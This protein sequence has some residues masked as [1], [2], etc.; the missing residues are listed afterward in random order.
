[1]RE[2]AASYERLLHGMCAT[3]QVVASQH[4]ELVARFDESEVLHPG[5]SPVAVAERIRQSA[6]AYH[7]AVEQC[8]LATAPLP[9]SGSGVPHGAALRASGTRSAAGALSPA[10]IQNLRAVVASALGEPTTSTPFEVGPTAAATHGEYRSR[11]AMHTRTPVGGGLAASGQGDHSMRF[12][13]GSSTLSEVHELRISLHTLRLRGTIADQAQGEGVRVSISLLPASLRLPMLTTPT[14]GLRGKELQLNYDERLTFSSEG[15]AHRQLVALLADAVGGGT[16]TRR[17]AAH[18]V[19][20]HLLLSSISTGGVV[21]TIGEATVP[22]PRLL[23]PGAGSRLPPTNLTN[24]N[25][26]ITADVELGAIAPG[27]LAAAERAATEANVIELQIHD[28]EIEPRLLR[29]AWGVWVQTDLFTLAYAASED[30]A[31]ENARESRDDRKSALVCTPA[32]PFDRASGAVH[33]SHTARVVVPPNSLAERRLLDAISAHPAGTV[34]LALSVYCSGPAGSTLLARGAMPVAAP[35]PPACGSAPPASS[36]TQSASHWPL[37]TGFAATGFAA[38][39]FAATGAAADTAVDAEAY[40]RRVPIMSDGSSE[41][42]ASVAEVGSV[43]VTLRCADVLRSAMSRAQQQSSVTV[44]VREMC[45]SAACQVDAGIRSVWVD[46]RLPSLLGMA[47]THSPRLYATRGV[48]NPAFQTQLPLNA[49]QLAQLGALLH[50]AAPPRGDGSLGRAE[51]DAAAL[52]HSAAMAEGEATQGSVTVSSE[53]N[54][55]DERGGGVATDADSGG[56]ASRFKRTSGILGRRLGRLGSGKFGAAATSSDDNSTAASLLEID[57]PPS[58]STAAATAPEVSPRRGASYLAAVM[59][60]EQIGPD[61]GAALEFVLRSDGWRGE[62]TMGIGRVDLKHML[63][64]GEEKLLV[65]IEMHDEYAQQVAVL[66]VSVQA[67]HALRLAWWTGARH[68]HIGLCA[69]SVRLQE[70]AVRAASSGG[71]LSAWLEVEIEGVASP[72]GR[73]AEVML[74]G[75]D[76]HFHYTSE[77]WVPAHSEYAR[78]LELALRGSNGAPIIF[79]LYCRPPDA[80]LPRSEA[81]AGSGGAAQP[82]VEIGTASLSLRALLKRGGDCMNTPLAMLDAHG[83]VAGQ[84]TLSVLASEAV[85]TLFGTRSWADEAISLQ[86]HSVSLDSGSSIVRLLSD[87]EGSKPG[88]AHQASLWI[89]VDFVGPAPNVLSEPATRR[90][91]SLDANTEQ[92]LA[93]SATWDIHLYEGSAALRA[94]R[95]ALESQ[96]EEDSDVYFVL[97][98]RLDTAHGDRSSRGRDVEL[99]TAHINLEEIMRL[100]AEPSARRLQLSSQQSGERVGWLTASARCLEALR[101]VQRG[102]AEEAHASLQIGALTL[103]Q[104]AAQ[105]LSSILASRKVEVRVSMPSAL[106]T[107]FATAG[108]PLWETSPVRVVNGKHKFDYHAAA[109]DAYAGSAVHAALLSMLDAAAVARS[110]G[111]AEAEAEAAVLVVRV[112]APAVGSSA[113]GAAGSNASNRSSNRRGGTTRGGAPSTE[114]DHGAESGAEFVIGVARVHLIDLLEGG[115]ELD[116]ASPLPLMAPNE[117]GP[118]GSNTPAATYAENAQTSASVSPHGAAKAASASPTRGGADVEKVPGQLGTLAVGTHFQSA[119]QIAHRQL[120]ARRTHAARRAAPAVPAAA[121]AMALSPQ[122]THV[123]GGARTFGVEAPCH[124]AIAT[125]ASSWDLGSTRAASAVAEYPIRAAATAMGIPPSGPARSTFGRV[126]SRGSHAVPATTAF[127]R[128]AAEHVRS[129]SASLPSL[130]SRG[131]SA[132]GDLESD[133]EDS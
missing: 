71:P 98:G 111:N 130:S 129:V 28:L 127:A 22:L 82:A 77:M 120:V 87:A 50:Q 91:S 8:T 113:A 3:L 37:A 103:H 125:S 123:G 84:L 86:V 4:L 15:D 78:R 67:L 31:A 128:Q 99:G 39:G 18:P 43:R 2:V 107:A 106:Q 25:G 117:R 21:R 79:R 96:E 100:G 112:V 126:P 76:L 32:L 59:A 115:I 88:D 6:H 49:S 26:D 56:S 47:P 17:D 29:G 102:L 38:T 48:L 114:A 42:G 10:H 19:A 81:A 20:L 74:N 80:T 85:T 122:H 44:G 27:L 97:K 119:L 105:R 72:L 51:R 75:L 14:Q 73:S 23:L 92:R 57:A 52:S 95:S 132:L 68:E 1:M 110:V 64:S 34:E 46:V 66:Q 116:E 58:A 124:R 12:P 121:C 53:R 13:S 109:V 62:R 33:Y 16:V 45:L 83:G 24:A 133:G 101:W 35:S 63:A 93:L 104:K 70:T 40:L 89:E 41:G 69:H 60:S 61:V 11:D 65:A 54:S 36:P 131:D 7:E 55:D 9:S 5:P 30:G 94:L 118:D 108:V 90:I